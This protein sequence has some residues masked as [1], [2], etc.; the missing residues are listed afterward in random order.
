MQTFVYRCNSAGFYKLP[1]K[2]EVQYARV[3]KYPRRCSCRSLNAGC[4]VINVPR[5]RCAEDAPELTTCGRSSVSPSSLPGI[6][7][8]KVD[9]AFLNSKNYCRGGEIPTRYEKRGQNKWGFRSVEPG[10]ITYDCVV[11]V[12]PLLLK[13]GILT[14]SCPLLPCGLPSCLLI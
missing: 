8:C 13:W 14:S 1:V 4:S 12:T 10:L 11:C 2:S 5:A 7:L 3:C 6:Q 9:R